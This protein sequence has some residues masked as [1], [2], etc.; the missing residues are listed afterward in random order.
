M[1]MQNKPQNYQSLVIKELK[2]TAGDHSLHIHLKKIDQKVNDLNPLYK[3]ASDI[4]L[5]N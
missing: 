3:L 2:W 4:A 5:H 1:E